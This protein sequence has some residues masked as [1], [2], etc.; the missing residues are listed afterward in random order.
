METDNLKIDTAKKRV[1]LVTNIIPPYRISLFERI[2]QEYDL[3]VVVSA[4]NEKHRQ[5]DNWQEDK[6]CK[7]KTVL[8]N[9]P[10]VN[11]KEGFFAAQPELFKVLDN[12]D[13]D[14]VINS[15]FSPN[16]LFGSRYA[17]K[18]NKK[19]ILWS[20]ATTHSERNRSLARKLYRKMLIRQNHGFI[21]SGIESK[22][23]LMSLGANPEKCFTAVDAIEN[24]RTEQ[25]YSD[26]LIKSM[27]L[28][29]KFKGTVLLFSG[30]LIKRKGIDLLFNAYEKIP[31]KLETTLLIMGNGPLEN[32]L[33]KLAKNKGLK[34]VKFV[35]FKDEYE[36][37]IYYLASDIY[38]M[39]TREDVWG[40]VVNEAL[41]A[42]LPVICSKYAGAA[43]D[44]VADGRSGFII[45]PFD[46]NQFTNR[47]TRTIENKDMLS[48]MQH[49][50]YEIISDYSIENSAQGFIDAIE[51]GLGQNIHDKI[52][53]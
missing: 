28:R 50:S 15:S 14:V 26:I 46:T 35:G 38:V 33:K 39:P 43:T 2:G 30:Q 32:E 48:S 1:A 44:L 40:L 36:K 12:I 3:T 27:S 7:F 45:D 23:Y 52:A 16:S 41:L 6:S 49:K 29:S 51:A 25:Q 13:P 42:G 8:L 34:N 53:L 19:A 4:A 47:L 22:K 9:G 24:F 10:V 21:A 18:H 17:K 20:E 5:W 31:D 11:H 37:W